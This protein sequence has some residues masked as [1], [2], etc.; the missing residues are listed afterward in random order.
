VVVLALLV[1][2]TVSSPGWPRVKE[3]FFSWPEAKRRYTVADI[4]RW[5]QWWGVPFQW[6]SK[7]PQR[8]LAAQRLILVANR[9]RGFDDA[10]ALAIAVARAMWAERRD[11]EDDATLA[12]LLADCAL[13]TDW[14]ERTKDPAVKQALVDST[15]AAA[16]AGVFGV[17]TFVVDGKV[18]IWGQDRLELVMRALGGWRP[19]HG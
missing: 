7:F 8:T 18:L 1:L 6:P 3:T 17:P 13:P 15:A 10:C 11:L 9:E 2:V 19:E 5:A 16:A 4:A 14:V 12:G